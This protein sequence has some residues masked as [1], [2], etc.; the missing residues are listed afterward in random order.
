M[1]RAS[2]SGAIDYSK[3]EH[4]NPLAEV[5]EAAI[6]DHLEG[7]ALADH[8]KMLSVVLASLASGP[9]EEPGNLAKSARE[10]AIS[11]NHDAY[12]YLEKSGKK[13]RGNLVERWSAAF[14]DFRDPEV[15]KKIKEDE[16]KLMSAARDARAEAEERARA[17][18]RG[19][20]ISQ[21]SSKRRARG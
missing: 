14:G 17:M 15:Q 21:K 6:L 7:E 11:A 16:E 8:K 9:F 12:P 10:L 13:R 2:V 20:S 4:R 19:P 5:R 1:L 3:W 18:F